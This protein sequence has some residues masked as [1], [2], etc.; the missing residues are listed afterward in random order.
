MATSVDSSEGMYIV[1]AFSGLYAPYWRSD[2]RGVMVGLTRMIN[3]NHICLAVL[4]STAYQ[5][6]DVFDA[7]AKDSGLRIKT[8]RVDGGMTK[9]AFLM[10]FQANILNTD[11]VIPMVTETTALGACFAAGLAVGY[12]KSL[13]DIREKW[14]IGKM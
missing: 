3:K 6:Y 1:P 12:W 14:M 13:E 10:Q 7:M 2:A 11:I 4:E 9:N 8:L 5:T